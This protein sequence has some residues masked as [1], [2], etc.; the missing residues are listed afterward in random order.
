MLEPEAASLKNIDEELAQPTNAESLKDF[1]NK[2][3]TTWSTQSFQSDRVD[4]G[5]RPLIEA[6]KGKPG[7]LAT[8]A[9]PS[10][11]EPIS[12]AFERKDFHQPSAEDIAARLAASKK[13]RHRFMFHVGPEFKAL[14]K[15]SRN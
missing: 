7:F 4:A 3:I 14:F 5:L 9:E 6:K 8:K 13:N 2:E 11:R 15:R 10:K 1:L 12:L